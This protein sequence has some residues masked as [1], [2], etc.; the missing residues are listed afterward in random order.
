MATAAAA[1]TGIAALTLLLGVYGDEKLDDGDEKLDEDGDDEY[2]LLT[3]TGN[4]PVVFEVDCGA[5]FCI[6]A[7]SVVIAALILRTEAQPITYRNVAKIIHG[8]A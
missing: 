4:D 8:N 6:L 5:D 2:P 3:G 7:L 1:A